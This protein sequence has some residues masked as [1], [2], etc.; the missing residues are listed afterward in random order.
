MASNK[1]AGEESLADDPYSLSKFMIGLYGED[2]E[3][4]ARAYA[5]S[6]GA[7][8]QESDA[9]VWNEAAALIAKRARIVKTLDS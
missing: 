2:A 5:L 8:G 7:K 6:I 4:Q 1:A 3:R 9:A